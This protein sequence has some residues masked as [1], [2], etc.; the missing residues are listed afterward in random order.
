MQG[1]QQSPIQLPKPSSGERTI[2]LSVTVLDE[3]RTNSPL[4][5]Y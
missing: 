5:S 4:F 2:L 3:F 1:L